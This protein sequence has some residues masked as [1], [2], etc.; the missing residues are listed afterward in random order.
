MEFE[1]VVLM[2]EA[3]M[4]IIMEGEPGRNM[5][6]GFNLPN[7]ILEASGESTW[8]YRLHSLLSSQVTECTPHK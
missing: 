8:Q 2:P 5:F 3:E 7:K 4:D 6:V 1:A